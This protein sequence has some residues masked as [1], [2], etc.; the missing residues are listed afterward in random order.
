MHYYHGSSE[1]FDKFKPGIIHLTPHREYAHKFATKYQRTGY[2]YTV[3]I[4]GQ[5]HLTYDKN[6]V[7]VTID[8]RTLKILDRTLVATVPIRPDLDADGGLMQ[9]IV[10]KPEDNI[11]LEI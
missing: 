2:V 4:P 8:T 7:N 11:D 5:D 3:H 1:K 10:L 6:M 9:Y